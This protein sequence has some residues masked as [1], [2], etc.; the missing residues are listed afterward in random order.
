[1]L[2]SK[3]LPIESIEE[4]SMEESEKR[5]GSSHHSMIR[6]IS[7]NSSYMKDRSF[8]SHSNGYDDSGSQKSHDKDSDSESESISSKNG[9]KKAPDEEYK[10]EGQPQKMMNDQASSSNKK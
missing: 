4:A 8:D 6:S 2:D 10:I 1:M 3:N 5:D 7:V 9:S